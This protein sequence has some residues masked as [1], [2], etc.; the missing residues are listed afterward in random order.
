[1]TPQKNSKR[2]I[3]HSFCFL[4]LNPFE[5]LKSEVA[6]SR[7]EDLWGWWAGSQIFEFPAVISSAFQTQWVVEPVQ[8]QTVSYNNNKHYNLF[9]VQSKI[10]SLEV[11]ETKKKRRMNQDYNGR[12]VDAVV[13]SKYQKTIV[14]EGTNSYYCKSYSKYSILI[15]ATTSTSCSSSPVCSLWAKPWNKVVGKVLNYPFISLTSN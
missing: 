3:G 12:L 5:F 10:W 9:S 14:M 1:M 8:K 13:K 4:S 7:N 6:K 15:F 2:C 11:E